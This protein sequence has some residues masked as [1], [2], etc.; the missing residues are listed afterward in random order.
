L[1][2]AQMHL[3]G[4]IAA[5]GTRVLSEASTLAMREPQVAV[6]DPY[7]LGSHWGL[8]WILMTWD[9]RAVYGHDGNTIGQASFL[10]VVPDANVA[11][12][13]LTNGGHAGDLYQDLY[14]EVLSQLA[15]VRPPARLEPPT[16]PPAL[17]LASYA[18]RYAREGIEI[19]LSVDEDHLTA[20]MTTSGALAGAMGTDTPPPLRVVPVRED[21]FVARSDSDESWTPMVFY[22]LAD[23]TP[24][25]HFGARAQPKIP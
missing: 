22:R 19:T 16:S 23:G 7:T 8:G 25:M 15:D 2:F 1:A 14:T 5:D 3:A 6:P 21:L 11:V 4:G 18:G 20:A 10:R 13:L 9:G 12:C 17:D 24:Y